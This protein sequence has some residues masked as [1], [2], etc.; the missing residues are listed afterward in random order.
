MHACNY[1]GLE[2]QGN[3]CIEYCIKARNMITH[4]HAYAMPLLSYGSQLLE[5]DSII[6]LSSILMGIRKLI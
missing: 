1:R 6:L 5:T 4:N 3:N 2:P